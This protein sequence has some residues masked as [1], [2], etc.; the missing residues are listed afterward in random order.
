M[1][2]VKEAPIIP[3]SQA[4]RPAVETLK[5]GG[6]IAFPTDTL[7]GLGCS[8]HRPRAIE[9]LL[10]LRGIDR[11]RR[12][13]TFMLPDLGELARYAQVTESGHAILSR[14]FPGPYCV[15][16]IAA[17]VVPE[18]HVCGRRRTIGVR[19]PDDPFCERMLWALGSPLLTATAKS[20]EG[21]LLTNPAEIAAELGSELDLIVDGGT[22]E[23][24]PST[25]VSLVDDWVTVLRLGRGD[26]DRLL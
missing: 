9:R 23:G 13:L 21:R 10:E 16:L 15:E 25:V 11:S 7:Y 24:L 14:I 22:R 18:P 12:P 4:E 2:L 8:F 19:I 17:A 6:I 3:L 20:H 26:P 1:P 5:A